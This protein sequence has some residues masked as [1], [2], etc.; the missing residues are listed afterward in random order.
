MSKLKQKSWTLLCL[1]QY[2][3][4]VYEYSSLALYCNFLSFLKNLQPSLCLYWHELSLQLSSCISSLQSDSG[5]T[6]LQQWPR[7]QNPLEWYWLTF[8]LPNLSDMSCFTLG[9]APSSK[10]VL[11]FTMSSLGYLSCSYFAFQNSFSLFIW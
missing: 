6:N 11:T 2:L 4:G 8:H 7:L 3:Q 1:S 10:S 5:C 9:S